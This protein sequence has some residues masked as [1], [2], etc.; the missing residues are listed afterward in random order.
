MNLRQRIVM[1]IIITWVG[2]MF[3]AFFLQTD[4]NIQMDAVGSMP[5]AVFLLIIVSDIVH[6]I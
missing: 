5:A 2:S 1:V 3:W 4:P 6:T